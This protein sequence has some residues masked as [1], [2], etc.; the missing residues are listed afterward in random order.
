MHEM[1]VVQPLSAIVRTNSPNPSSSALLHSV[2]VMRHGPG[3]TC[4]LEGIVRSGAVRVGVDCASFSLTA[5]QPDNATLSAATK[6][7]A[8]IMCLT[9]PVAIV[10][11]TKASDNPVKPRLDPGTLV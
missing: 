11:A 7:N 10:G 6:T 3:W 8:F 1:V 5:V 2:F 4:Q 9:N